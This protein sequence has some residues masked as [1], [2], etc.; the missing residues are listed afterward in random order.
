MPILVVATSGGVALAQLSRDVLADRGRQAPA[1]S[2]SST[3]AA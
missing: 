2:N 1:R 3:S